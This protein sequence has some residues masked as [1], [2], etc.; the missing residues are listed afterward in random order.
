MF[1]ISQIGSC[2]TLANTKFIS[3]YEP[4]YAT[5]NLFTQLPKTSQHECFTTFQKSHPNQVY[6]L[7]PPKLVE[8]K[9]KES[10]SGQVQCSS[11]TL[12]AKI[13]NKC[14]NL[15]YWGRQC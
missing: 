11:F 9:M 2:S 4:S 12:Q 3:N 8:S 14:H 6:M 13:D 10:Q 15:D 7:V 5:N 1:K